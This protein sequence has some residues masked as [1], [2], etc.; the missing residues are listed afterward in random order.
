MALNYFTIASREWRKVVAIAILTALFAALISFVRPLEYSSTIRLLIIQRS[1]LGLDPYTAI[2]SAERVSE[3]LANIV[4]TTSFFDKVLGAGYS[5]DQSVFPKD[6]IK[7]RKQW[8]RMVETEVSRGTGLLT[9]AVYHR[10]RAQAEE[11]ASAM[12][13]VLQQEGWTYVGGGDLQ[14]KVVDAPLTS[15]WPVRPNVPVNA[16]GGFV[17]GIIAGT[18]YVVWFHRKHPLHQEH[19]FLHDI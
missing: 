19:G 18:G 5:I 4:Y 2:R 16:F 12:G 10:D 3:N 7:R 1:A 14:V 11:I 17:L 13:A 9:V 8:Q 15:R 6:E